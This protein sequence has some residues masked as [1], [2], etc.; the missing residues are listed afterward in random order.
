M[1][2]YDTFQ[3]HCNRPE[4]MGPRGKKQQLKAR[5]NRRENGSKEA[6]ASRPIVD[7]DVEEQAKKQATEKA[8]EQAIEQDELGNEDDDMQLIKEH[9]DRF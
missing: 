6:E 7:S 3:Q 4:K 8:I 2:Y 5:A 1:I 9:R